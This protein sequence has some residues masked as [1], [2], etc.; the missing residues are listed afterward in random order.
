[1]RTRMVYTK[2]WDDDYVQSLELS[3]K[4]LYMF[5][6]TNPSIGQN[7]VFQISNRMIQF[8]TGIA[9]SDVVEALEKFEND[10]KILRYGD[11]IAILNVHKYNTFNG[12]I[13]ERARRSEWNNVPP[14][15]QKK[16]LDTQPIDYIDYIAPAI[17]Q[18]DMAGVDVGALAKE[19]GVSV[20]QVSNSL[21]NFEDYHEGRGTKI[22][23]KKRLFKTWIRNDINNGK[24]TLRED[25][26]SWDQ[27]DDFQ[28]RQIMDKLDSG[29]FT[30][31][32]KLPAGTPIKWVNMYNEKWP[33]RA[34][35]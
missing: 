28:K 32:F 10:K 25:L 20:D 4:V 11:W 17:T 21:R 34:K 35:E 33:S 15:L 8:F 9:L 30:Q 18:G 5:L 22:K 27:L 23:D 12:P 24:V 14:Q 31:K 13:N 2:F 19:F 6:L 16:L 1:M 29:S 7:G 3:A 26:R